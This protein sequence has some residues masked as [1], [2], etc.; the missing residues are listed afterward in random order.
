MSVFVFQKAPRLRVPCAVNDFR[1]AARSARTSAG[2]EWAPSQHSDLGFG[3]S[4][5][6]GVDGAFFS[7]IEPEGYC[8]SNRLIVLDIHFTPVRDGAGGYMGFQTC[9]LCLRS[10][11]T[12]FTKL[13]DPK[14]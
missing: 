3:V 13:A 4:G 12:M 2:E 11:V 7:S 9:G 1:K 10:T 8:S 5:L 6:L 14:P